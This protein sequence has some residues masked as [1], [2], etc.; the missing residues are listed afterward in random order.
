MGT[1]AEQHK[2]C[3]ATLDLHLHWYIID[4]RLIDTIASFDIDSGEG[5]KTLHI[6]IFSLL[7]LNAAS[8]CIWMLFLG[9]NLQT[10]FCAILS[11]NEHL[12]DKC[13]WFDNDPA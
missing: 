7:K 6:L 11:M 5:L 2:V 1:K 10:D 8:K 12:F 13:F 3:G 4:N 9:T